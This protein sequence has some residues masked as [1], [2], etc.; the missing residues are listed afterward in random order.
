VANDAMAILDCT[1][2]M[3]QSVWAHFA[4]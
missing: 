4:G 1:L 3:R 2:E